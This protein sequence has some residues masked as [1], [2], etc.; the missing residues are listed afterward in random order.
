MVDVPGEDSLHIDVS[1]S[2]VIE[3]Y[4]GIGASVTF[5]QREEEGMWVGES[6]LLNISQGL[7]IYTHQTHVDTHICTQYI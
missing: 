5:F 3:Y 7:S 2:P 6:T 1:T 4:R